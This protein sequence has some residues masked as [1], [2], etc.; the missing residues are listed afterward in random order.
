MDNFVSSDRIVT[1]LTAVHKARFDRNVNKIN[2]QIKHVKCECS[3]NFDFVESYHQRQLAWVVLGAGQGRE[4]GAHLVVT[5]TTPHGENCHVAQVF[6]STHPALSHSR[7]E[8][9]IHTEQKGENTDRSQCWGLLYFV[10]PSVCVCSIP[11]RC[12][13]RDSTGAW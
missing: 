3:R 11:S 5:V 1:K 2:V 12:A 9:Y 8:L 6:R 13:S 4:A 7:V 10:S